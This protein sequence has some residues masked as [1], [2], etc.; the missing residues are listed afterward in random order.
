MNWPPRHSRER[1]TVQLGL[2]SDPAWPI[3]AIT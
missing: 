1:G 2:V 3:S